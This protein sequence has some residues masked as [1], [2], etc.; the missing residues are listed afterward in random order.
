MRTMLFAIFGGRRVFWKLRNQFSS[1]GFV[2]RR[3]A[4]GAKMRF[5]E[6]RTQTG[7]FLRL[8]VST[9]AAIFASVL[10][11][12]VT[13]FLDPLLDDYY[14]RTGLVILNDVYSTLL[15]TIAGMGG[16]FIGLYYAATIAISGAIYARVPNNIRDLL[17]RERVGNVY[18]RFLALLTYTSVVLLSMKAA[19]FAPNKLGASVVLIGAGIAVIAFVKLGARAFYLFDPTSLASELV[20]QIKRSYNLVGPRQ[21]RWL[22]PSFQSHAYRTARQSL[23][24]VEA[25]AEITGKEDKLNAQP[26]AALCENLLFLL[27][28]YSGQKRKIPTDSRW[29]PRQYDHA[30]WYRSND[31][32][33]S[34]SSQ[35]AGRLNPKEVS[36]AQWLEGSILS[37]VHDGF[38]KNV[39]DGRYDLSTRLVQGIDILAR[40]LGHAHEVPVGFKIINDLATSY[41][42]ALLPKK[43]EGPEFEPIEAVALADT[44][45][46]IPIT[47]FL[48]YAEAIVKDSRE[49][50]FKSVKSIGWSS[51]SELY[52]HGLPRHLLPQLEWLYP[53][54]E[55]ERRTEASRSSPDWYVFELVRQAACEDLKLSLNAFIVTAQE[56]FDKW[57][58]FAAEQGAYWVRAAIIDREA[59]YWSKVDYQFY[60]LRRHWDELSADNRIE[61]L[62]WP[63]VDF[64]DLEERKARRK[65]LLS[66]MMAEESTRLGALN[67][68][69]AY[70][71]FAGQFLHS[72]G[73]R[74]LAAL[75]DNDAEAVN[76]SFGYYF[77]SSLMQFDHL[78][79]KA[80]VQDWRGV[81]AMKVAI[82]PV[83]DLM[84][85]SGYGLLLA[86]VHNNPKLASR[87]IDV[88]N[89]YLDSSKGSGAD[90]LTLL[91]SAISITDSAFEIA[92][93][94]LIRTAWLQSVAH[95][96][97]KI[98]RRN[99][100]VGSRFGGIHRSVADHESAL[101]RVFAEAD[102]LPSYD[103]VDVFVEMLLKKRADTAGVAIKPRRLRLG[104]T[105]AREKKRWSQADARDVDDEQEFDDEED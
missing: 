16:V 22:D 81:S 104:E 26:Y 20:Q 67:R 69:S 63:K 18:M 70:P 54:I 14:K 25:L 66:K 24:T 29:Y 30:D 93:R 90:V 103:G 84:S 64:D 5:R 36:D 68:P 96:L 99:I 31:A 48:A 58:A 80:D 9:F 39:N 89:E 82:A 10:F 32:S 59:E 41:A 37:I 40:S 73:E 97:G 55:F 15:A 62:P 43:I 7:T 91:I 78:R 51:R 101:V 94:S 56:V 95:A 8:S 27:A 4:F 13:Q 17:A 42:K 44:M 87:I 49:A 21:F 98:K 28:D 47:L 74:L 19:G 85:A 33:T 52:E 102:F 12:S 1:L 72:V 23:D 75:V 2:F 45:A 3:G 35:G 61:G 71:D 6:N 86:E 46:T 53:R 83:L 34:L 60:R 92:H 105:I 76:E 88:W 100:R 50:I 65:K 79:A 77:V 38:L 11:A 57:L